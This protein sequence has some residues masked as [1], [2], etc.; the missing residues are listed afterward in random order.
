MKWKVVISAPYFQPVLS[1]YRQFFDTNDIEVIV[2]EVHE[3]LSEEELLRCITDADGIICGDD[4]ITER[5]LAA[6]PKLKVIAKWG[7]GIDSIDREAAARRGIP[8]RNTPN[9]F[10]DAVADTAF[11]YILNFSRQLSWMDDD[12]RAGQWQKRPLVALSESVLG[13]IGFGHIGQAVARRARGFGVRVFATDIRPGLEEVAASM[14]VTMVPLDELLSLSDFISLHCDLNPTTHHLLNDQTIAR[15]KIGA[16]VINTA[17]GPL[18]DETALIAAL[19][20]G[21]VAGAALDV[22]EHEPLPMDHLLRGFRNVLFAPHNSNASPSAWK[23]VHE[24]TL[25]NLLDGFHR[26]G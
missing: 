12:V 14:A 22:F 11:G 5:V 23:R 4:R 6:A 18:I 25:K 3:R 26:H 7:T 21:K 1:E 9:A 13:I 24:N 20:S 16:V 10:T 17:R 8:V 2:P 19:G 15:M